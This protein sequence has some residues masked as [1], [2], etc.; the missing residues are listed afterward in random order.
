MEID[1]GRFFL[2]CTAFAAMLTSISIESAPVMAQDTFPTRPIRIINPLP[3]GSAPDVVVRLVAE[4][5]TNSLGQQV[6][7]ENRP[8]GSNIIAAQAVAAAAPDGYTLLGGAA[9]TFTILPAEKE[10]L[11]FDVN[12][13]FIQVG[14]IQYGPLYLAV[15]VKL[16]VTSLPELIAM[17]R[18]RPH[19]IVIGTNGAGTLPNFAGLALAKMGNI[20]ITVVPYATGGTMAAI[21]DIL[22]GRVHATIE[23]LGGLRGSLQSGDLKLIAVMSTER[24]PLYADLPTVAETVPGLNAVGWMSLAAPAGTPE[25]I[26]RRLNEGLRHALEAPSVMHR[27]DELGARAKIMTPEETKAFVES[28]EKLWWPIVKEA[29]PK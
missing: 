18:S 4:Q 28:E 1:M 24:D 17:A 11:P 21:T 13:D 2:A 16:G 9:S 19:E 22:G 10:S 12:H 26:V 29:G 23:S 8:G 14:M 6:I 7:V 3:A 15:P 25:Y 20:P 27:L 5:L